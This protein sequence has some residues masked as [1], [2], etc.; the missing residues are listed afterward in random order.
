MGEF[1]CWGI[2]SVLG[3]LPS[4]C[5][6]AGGFPNKEGPGG[7]VMGREGAGALLGQKAS[8]SS[9]PPAAK[10]NPRLL[11]LGCNSSELLQNR[12]LLGA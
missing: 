11:F 7:S 5:L 3:T 2:I 1:L 6:P 12:L 8:A 9:G 4:S 10:A